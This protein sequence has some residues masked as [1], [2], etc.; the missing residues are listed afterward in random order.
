FALGADAGD[1]SQIV[2][3]AHVVR[4][5]YFDLIVVDHFVALADKTA[6]GNDGVTPPHILDH[7]L[8]LLHPLLLR[9]KD[10]E[11]HDDENQR[12]REQ[13]YQHATFATCSTEQR[14]LRKRRRYEH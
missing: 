3:D 7:F 14:A 8:M 1:H 11:I 2:G 4:I 6:I 5:F 12:E 13:R 9:T 10:Q